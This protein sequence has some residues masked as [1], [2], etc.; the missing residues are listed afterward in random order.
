MPCSN[1]DQ[2]QVLPDIRKLG[3]SFNPLPAYSHNGDL[4]YPR[5][6]DINLPNTVVVIKFTL[7]R[8]YNPETRKFQYF[9]DII[10]IDTISRLRV[11]HKYEDINM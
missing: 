3:F 2:K 6:Y 1:E 11:L 8:L 5:L 9:T 7:S 10:K 4:M